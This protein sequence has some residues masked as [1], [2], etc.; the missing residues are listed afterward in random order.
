MKLIPGQIR[1]QKF[2]YIQ[3][4]VFDLRYLPV[5]AVGTWQVR[6]HKKCEKIYENVKIFSQFFHGSV[7]AKSQDLPLVDG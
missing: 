5:A 1:I 7:L 4:I 6:Y 3:V 2:C